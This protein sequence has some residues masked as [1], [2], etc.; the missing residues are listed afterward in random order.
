MRSL[1]WLLLLFALAGCAASPGGVAA[2]PLPQP[3]IPAV[4]E[5]L[6]DRPAGRFGTIGYLYMT[7][8]GVALVGGLSFSHGDTPTPLDALGAIWLP[9]PPPLPADAPVES[10]GATRYLIVRAQGQLSAPGSYGPGGTYPRQLTEVLLEP[11]GVREL[12]IPLLLANSGIYDNQPVRL[13]GQLLL[14]GTTTALLVD[15]LGSGGVPEPS[16]QQIKLTAPI[17]DEQLRARLTAT[18][19][20]TARFGPVQIIGIWRRSS[21]YPLAIIPG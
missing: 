11:L 17:T 15:R 8:A 6:S 18:P 3:T 9:S 13:S 14:G 12:S 21:L 20:G 16:A 2:T 7:D 4:A 19:G 10:A 1:V 5:G